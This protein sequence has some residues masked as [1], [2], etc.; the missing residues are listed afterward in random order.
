[1]YLDGVQVHST[2]KAEARDEEIDN[3]LE[4]Q[5]WAVLRI[6]YDPPLQGGK[7]CEVV[8]QIREFIGEASE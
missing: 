1:M 3:L 2:D 8:R 6:R 5:G 7:L 4:R